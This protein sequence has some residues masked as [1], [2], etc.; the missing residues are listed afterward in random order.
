MDFL[1]LL[2]YA[3]TVSAF[4]CI[5]SDLYEKTKTWLS[6]IEMCFIKGI[7][8]QDYVDNLYNRFVFSN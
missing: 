8:P 5:V 2:L 7:L 3:I 4:V 1:S 6:A